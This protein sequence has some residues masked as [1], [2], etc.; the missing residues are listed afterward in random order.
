MSCGQIERVIKVTIH[1]ASSHIHEKLQL[2]TLLS[3][4]TEM[5]P[6]KTVSNEGLFNNYASEPQIY[7]AQYPDLFEQR[8]YLRQGLMAATFVL[9]MLFVS[10][11]VS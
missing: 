8:T 3:E 1:R 10:F 7:Y 6:M 11:A 4:A 2:V 5:T 9:F